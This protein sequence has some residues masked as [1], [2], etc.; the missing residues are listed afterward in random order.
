MSNLRTHS[1]ARTPRLRYIGAALLICLGQPALASDV[2]V[3]LEIGVEGEGF[4]FNPVVTKINVTGVEAESLAAK[5]GIVKGDEITSIE[6]QIVKGRRASELKGYM[7][8]GAGE[9]RT[10]VVRHADGGMFEARLVKPKE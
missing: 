8:F 1:H 3:G 10:L 9:S 5:A 2:K 7:K 6:G 4:L